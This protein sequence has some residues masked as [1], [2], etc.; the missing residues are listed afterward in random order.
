VPCAHFA[1]QFGDHQQTV[2]V[3]HLA[4]HVGK[5][6]AAPAQAVGF[7]QNIRRESAQAL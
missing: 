1:A 2:M 6:N 4:A 3:K 7:Q 5:V